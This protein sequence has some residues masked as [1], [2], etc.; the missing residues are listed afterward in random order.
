L[1]GELVFCEIDL[2]AVEAVRR[3]MPI[4]NHRRMGIGLKVS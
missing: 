1:A 4:N 2:G 3:K